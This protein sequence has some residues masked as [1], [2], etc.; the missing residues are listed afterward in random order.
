VSPFTRYLLMQTPGWLAVAAGLGVLRWLADLPIWIV[1]VGIA[2][3]VA[4][5]LAMYRVVRPTLRPPP[6]R[7]VGI[8]G[9]AIERLAPTGYVRIEGELWRGEAIGG[10]IAAGAEVVVRES[11]GLT[12]HVE[13]AGPR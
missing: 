11:R 1:P 2:A 10:A 12:L 6:E 13:P 4:K 8:R 3:F 9:R 7:L 5:D